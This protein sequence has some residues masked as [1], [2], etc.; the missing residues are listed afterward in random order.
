VNPTGEHDRLHFSHLPT[1][2]E[3]MDRLGRY[4]GGPL[5][6]I[7]RDDC[8]GLATGGN[9]ARKLEFL[10]ADAIAARA[11]VVVTQGPI[12]SNHARQTAAIASKLSMRCAL[13]LEDRAEGDDRL[14][15]GSAN[16]LLDRLYG[17][18]VHLFPE[19]SDM[20]SAT[21]GLASRYE[22]RG[23]RP[24]VI[25]SGGSNPVGALGYVSCA[26][27]IVNQLREQGLR[28]DRLVHATVGGST[29]AGL[30][31]GFQLAA[32]KVPVLGIGV[33]LPK[34]ALERKVYDLVRQ[35]SEHLGLEQIPPRDDVAVDSGDGA[36]YGIPTAGALAAVAAVARYESILLDPVYTG[37][38]MDRLIGLIAD[39]HH[40]GRDE[41][42]LFLHTG[43]TVGLF[44]CM[45]RIDEF[46]TQE[47]RVASRSFEVG[48]RR[49][50]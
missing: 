44:G 9:S 46:L 35:T 2:L 43:G 36:A 11:D 22:A 28:I 29:Q 42:I 4:L 40:F 15:C 48:T 50:W 17:A 13:A 10:M 41:N 45:T 25:P 14:H 20:E 30:I 7:K 34:A 26:F 16:V 39:R 37:K 24:Y 33:G 8:T 18:D 47:G 1:P 5:L 3:P 21:R 38:A 27:E 31:V 19:G 12:Q 6:F 49:S 23:M 32:M